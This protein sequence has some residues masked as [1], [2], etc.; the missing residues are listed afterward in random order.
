MYAVFHRIKICLAL[1]S[2]FLILL[3]HYLYVEMDHGKH[4]DAGVLESPIFPAADASLWN[5]SSLIYGKCQASLQY[6]TFFSQS[7]TI[8][9]MHSTCGIYIQVYVYIFIKVLH[10]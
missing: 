9:Y 7:Y 8:Y 5:S 10:I 3:G 6:W 2:W 1:T 4:L